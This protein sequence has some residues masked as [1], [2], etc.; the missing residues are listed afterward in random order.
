MSEYDDKK[1][2]SAKVKNLLMTL[3]LVN[4]IVGDEFMNDAYE[5]LGEEIKECTEEGPQH[6]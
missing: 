3:S 1:N 5:F 2:K 6:E 4:A